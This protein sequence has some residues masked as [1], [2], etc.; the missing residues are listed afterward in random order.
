MNLV[1]YAL[2]QV[3]GLAGLGTLPIGA[4]DSWGFCTISQPAERIDS[5]LIGRT[6]G[7]CAL[8]RKRPL[9]RH[10]R[11]SASPYR[12]VDLEDKRHRDY[13][14][15]SM[16]LS[17]LLLATGGLT[18]LGAMQTA[19]NV[20]RFSR[21]AILSASALRG[22]ARGQAVMLKGLIDQQTPNSAWGLAIYDCERWET[23]V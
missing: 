9:R 7:R 8:K 17:L 21:S 6:A 5:R 13:Q 11:G 15:V 1:D 10:G 19:A 16:V 20:Q 22:S 14:A 12:E 3:E 18:L 4:I 2:D 23:T